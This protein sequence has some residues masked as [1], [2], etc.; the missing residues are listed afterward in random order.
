MKQNYIKFKKSVLKSA[1]YFTIVLLFVNQNLLSQEY[2]FE[3]AYGIGA[4]AQAQDKAGTIHTDNA[5][6]VYITGAYL[7]PAD[8]DP[9]TGITS[10]NSNFFDAY[11]SKMDATGNLVW[12]KNFGGTNQDVGRSIAVDANDNVYVIGDFYG[13]WV[14]DPGNGSV[15]LNSNGYNDAFITKFDN[16][17]NIVWVKTF[18]GTFF[19]Y[20]YGIDVDNA[21][22][23]Y[24]TGSFWQTVDFDP[25]AGVNNLTA[26]GNSDIFLAKY[27]TNGDLIWAKSIGANGSNEG[28]SLKLDS[29]NNIYLT[30]QFSGTVDFDPGVGVENLVGASSINGF[31]A[32]YDEDGN[33]IWAEKISSTN[34][35]KGISL[36]IDTATNVYVTGSFQ[37]TATFDQGAGTIDLNSNGGNDIFIAKYNE[38]GNL[39]WAKGIGNSGDDSGEGISVD[40][41]GHC[42]ITGKFTDSIDLDP[43]VGS[44]SILS[45][46]GM[47]AFIL[48][49]N[50]NGEFVW[51]KHVGGNSTDYGTGISVDVFNNIYVTGDFSDT[52]DFD[53]GV[54][55]NEVVSNGSIDIFVLKLSC[56]PTTSTLTI[57]ACESYT[58]NGVT[59]TSS[60]NTATDTLVNAYGCDSIITL[61]L[62]ITTIDAS[63]TQEGDTVYANVAGLDYQ[64]ID[65]ANNSVIIGA[66]NQSYIATQT[67]DYAV[68]LSENSC[69][70][71]SD[72]IHVT[73]TNVG[74]KEIEHSILNIFPNPTTGVITVSDLNLN[75][76]VV[77][78]IDLNGKIILSIKPVTTKLDLSFLN[79]GVYLIEINRGNEILKGKLIK[80]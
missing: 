53:S 33:Y 20:G 44:F 22:N 75:K 78:I 80:E 47:D 42:Y 70:D 12:A 49:L 58:F 31:V 25:G 48:R 60:N 66:T 26:N 9:D 1:Q 55:V 16:L 34:I 17:G 14:Y 29:D 36:S 6:N 77:S 76:D 18:G 43:G 2:A 68:V 50:D 72:C 35:T 4:N 40:I 67:G 27:T 39:Y 73:I 3:W 45:N 30:G 37:A 28:R 62:T 61:D 65:C 23:L 24:V 15:A 74:I 64:W 46:G 71:T 56:E 5:G 69:S 57:N 13:S 32:K 63:T 54:A 38:N 41:L 59:Y 11:I 8:F 10:L 51:G 79:R 19:E 52:A 21:G 7:G